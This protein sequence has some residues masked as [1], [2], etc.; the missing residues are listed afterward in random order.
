MTLTNI[1]LATVLSA[2][3]SLLLLSAAGQRISLVAEEELSVYAKPTNGEVINKL[4]KEE[5]IPVIGCADLKHYIV[6]IIN[7]DG[8]A[9]YIVE[10]QFHLKKRKAWDLGGGPISFS[11]P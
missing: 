7:I 11:C 10:G 3:T 4:Q 8:R 1:V 5:E 9:G 2:T 6:P